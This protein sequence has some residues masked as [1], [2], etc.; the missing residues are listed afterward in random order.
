MDVSGNV[1][2][3]PNH[4]HF[5]LVDNGTSGIFGV[6]IE[7]RAKIEKAISYQRIGGGNHEDV[8]VP[9]V[10]VAVEGG[11][12]T[13]LTVHEAVTHGTP[14]VIVNGSGRAANI[15]SLAAQKATEVEVKDNSGGKEKKKVIGKKLRQELSQLIKN[16]D[17]KELDEKDIEIHLNRIEK[18]VQ[19]TNLFNVYDMDSSTGVKNIDE[20][21]LHALLRANKGSKQ[22]QLKLT[23]VWNRI[24]IAKSQLF[25]DDKDWKKGEL[26][27][28]LHYSLVHDQ[29]DFV[30]LFLDRGVSLKE[31]LTVRKLSIL[32]NEVK[33][34]TPI[35]K[36]LDKQRGGRKDQFNLLDVGKLLQQM[37]MDSYK[38]LYLRDENRYM[39]NIPENES[40]TM[41]IASTGQNRV[42]LAIAETAKVLVPNIAPYIVDCKSKGNP[43]QFD[44]PIRELLIWSVLQGRKEMS[45]YFWEE[46]KELMIAA[47]LT[48]CMILKNMSQK[49]DAADYKEQ[50]SEMSNEFEDYAIGVLNECYKSDEERTSA[51]LVRELPQW[52]LATCLS[53]AFH[54][55][56]KKF[57]SQQGVQN[58]LSEIWMGKISKE[59]SIY[60]LILCA[61]FPPLTIFLIKFREDENLVKRLGSKRKKASSYIKAN[62]SEGSDQLS[63][64]FRMDSGLKIQGYNGAQDNPEKPTGGTNQKEDYHHANGVDIRDSGKVVSWC[65]RFKLFHESPKIKFIYNLICNFLFLALF[66]YIML[67]NFNKETSVAEYILL[68]WVITLF[69]EEFRQMAQGEPHS[70]QLRLSFW[71][72]DYW[73]KVDVATLILFTVGFIMRL[74][75]E[76]FAAS[77]IVFAIDLMLFYI[78]L[79]QFFSVSKTLGPKLIM[80]SKMRN[81]SLLTCTIII[82]KMLDLDVMG[83]QV[84]KQYGDIICRSNNGAGFLAQDQ[85]VELLYSYKNFHP[86][87]TSGLCILRGHCILRK[88]DDFIADEEVYN[89]TTTLEEIK[90]MIHKKAR[91]S[92]YPGTTIRR[93]DV[94]DAKVSWEVDFPSYA[95]KLY[96]HQSVLDKPHWADIDV[97]AM[98][99]DKRPMLQFNNEDVHCK[100]DRRSHVQQYVVKDGLPLN[101]KG[102]TGMIGRGL[103]G[104]F[105]PNHAA[106]PIVTRW[107]KNPD[108]SPMMD[109]DKKVLEF[110][111]IQRKDNHQWAIPGGMVE[112]GQT[113]SETLRR[114]FSEEALGQMT[115]CTEEKANMAENIEKLFENGIEI[116]RGYVDDPRNTDNAWIETYALN[117]HIES[118]SA[119]REFKLE[120]GD[121]AQSV[122]WQR[123]SSK[124]PLF[125]SHT[126]ILRKVAEKHNAAF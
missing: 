112:P 83:L 97:M 37:T 7:L 11:P 10:C 67:F 5:L 72:A 98:S 39:L 25:T 123:V 6:E 29:V 121:D 44:N 15:L 65:Q 71:I 61:A 28:A 21:F 85:L 108:G 111:A 89:M 124:I 126:A 104:R 73:N 117:F 19:K 120:A 26:D 57:V 118:D 43:N 94:P 125:A 68:F 99:K 114:E 64:S 103:L 53:L 63:E 106:D 59:N 58:L 109:G 69:M 47:A 90:I 110:I 119:I 80:I 24:D 13:I 122:R 48:S 52:G 8:C 79:L 81:E 55:K 82:P 87:Y 100:V 34:K 116:Y 32:Y 4:T 22:D 54:G 113:V 77:R 3:D 84:S 17:E 91:Q 35:Y 76:S 88:K 78:R 45:H 16:I 51:I 92:P 115:K 46:C 2:L 31:F 27:S 23:L 56:M 74:I 93:A 9:T 41:A 105:G 40:E 12:N 33:E 75:N 70:W 18:C 101:P 30:K 50:L 49:Q 36:Y 102:R 95:P 1:K 42:S 60:R 38:P 66:S 20:A 107:K 14:A 62:N 86:V 96:T